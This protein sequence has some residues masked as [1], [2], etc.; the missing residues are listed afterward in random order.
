MPDLATNVLYYRDNVIF[1]YESGNAIGT[2]A[3]PSELAGGRA[4]RAPASRGWHL[5]LAGSS[6]K[7]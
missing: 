6:E 5:R 7:P 4:S 2:W 1:R 3:C